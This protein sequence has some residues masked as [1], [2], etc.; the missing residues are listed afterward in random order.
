L[1][2]W[3]RCV[4][5]PKTFCLNLARLY[6]KVSMHKPTQLVYALKIK[7]ESALTVLIPECMEPRD[8]RRVN[9]RLRDRLRR[10]VEKHLFASFYC[11]FYFFDR[12]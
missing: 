10:K 3:Y 11:F 6:R 5:G 9:V 12:T 8:L 4:R 7:N 2:Q 1:R